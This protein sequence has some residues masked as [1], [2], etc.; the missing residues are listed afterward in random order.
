M[1][2]RRCQKCLLNA[3]GEV[4]IVVATAHTIITGF[5]ETLQLSISILFWLLSKPIFFDG[6]FSLLLRSHNIY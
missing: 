1:L 3:L 5:E 6:V 4:A 2:H